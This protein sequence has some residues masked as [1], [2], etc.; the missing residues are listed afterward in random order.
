MCRLAYR[1]GVTTGITA[2]TG[3]GFLQGISAA[4]RLGAQHALSRGAI[5]QRD[6]AVH[7]SL[8]HEQR[9]SVSTQV[10]ALRILLLGHVDE[11]KQESLILTNVRKVSTVH[12]FIPASM[13]SNLTS[14]IGTP[15]RIR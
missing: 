13:R 4:F 12:Y 8:N 2:P 9:V 1:S 11:A 14:G 15:G 5:I 10:A 7:I 6:T 3:Y